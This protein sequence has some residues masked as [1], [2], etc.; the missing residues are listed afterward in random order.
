LRDEITAGREK[1][2]DGH[3]SQREQTQRPWLRPKHKR[4]L[5]RAEHHRGR[6]NAD[7]VEIIYCMPEWH[8]HISPGLAI[9]YDKR[10]HHA[11]R[12]KILSLANLTEAF[13]H[14]PRPS[15]KPQETIRIRDAD[16]LA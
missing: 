6:S 13:Y 3:G 1:N 8:R 5:M 14:V 9:S 15:Q 16:A 12:G 4:V 10:A 7:K 11:K 2:K